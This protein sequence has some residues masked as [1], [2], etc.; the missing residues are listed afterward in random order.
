MKYSNSTEKVLEE[1]GEKVGKAW[2]PSKN[3]IHPEPEKRVVSANKFKDTPRVPKGYRL[4]PDSE[5]RGIS[6]LTG[7]SFY[8]YTIIKLR[9]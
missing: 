5:R 6:E 9:C 8:G 7:M 4:D 2:Y 3:L 1:Q